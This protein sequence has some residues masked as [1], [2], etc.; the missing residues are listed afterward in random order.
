MF[1]VFA[2]NEETVLRVCCLNFHKE[3]KIGGSQDGGERARDRVWSRTM[4]LFVLKIG[5]DHAP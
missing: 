5:F 3:R 2:G 4:L 1:R